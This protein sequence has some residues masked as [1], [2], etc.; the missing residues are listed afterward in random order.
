MLLD[1]LWV[2]DSCQQ[3]IGQGKPLLRRGEADG[4]GQVPLVIVVDHQDTLTGGV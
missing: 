2:V 1:V 3:Q 4:G